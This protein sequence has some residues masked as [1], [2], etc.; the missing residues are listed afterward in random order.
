MTSFATAIRRGIG[1]RCPSCGAGA[2]F[3]GW[4]KLRERC[5]ACGFVY[6]EPKGDNFAF[7]YLSMAFLNGVLFLAIYFFGPSDWTV[8]RVTLAVAIV[9]FNVLTIPFRKAISLG[10]DLWVD[11]HDR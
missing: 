2:V 5:D 10:I 11:E 4:Y 7:M 8:K 9:A 1:R 3:R 6:R